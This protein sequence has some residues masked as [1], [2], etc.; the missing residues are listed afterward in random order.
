MVLNLVNLNNM[1]RLLIILLTILPFYS[2][3]QQ[4]L[5][6]Y[7]YVLNSDKIYAFDYTRNFKKV[8]NKYLTI[9]NI[10]DPSNRKHLYVITATHTK[11]DKHVSIDVNEANNSV[12]A[13]LNTEETNYENFSLK[14]FGFRGSIGELGGDKVPNQIEVKFA[15]TNYD[16][17]KVV[18]VNG[19]S[20]GTN[21]FI[22][23]ILDRH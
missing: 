16:Y 17:V 1:K 8:G 19:T 6:G 12:F 18:N 11:E 2:F 21:D 20:P 15:S 4:F 23:F 9:Y 5:R 3:S 7:Q 10:Y 14:S 22:F 13:N